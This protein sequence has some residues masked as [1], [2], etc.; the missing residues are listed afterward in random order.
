[1]V[2]SCLIICIRFQTQLLY[3]LMAKIIILKKKKIKIHKNLLMWS[4]LLSSHL[5]LKVTFFLYCHR[6]L[7]MNW[8]SFK[9]SHV[10]IEV[11]TWT[12]LTVLDYERFF[13]Q[14][15]P[16]I[17]CLFVFFSFLSAVALFFYKRRFP[18]NGIKSRTGKTGADDNKTNNVFKNTVNPV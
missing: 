13:K 3:S 1:M 5:Y 18:R 11:I 7:N 12:G 14:H 17:S 10:L 6:K 9:R 4:P 8:T 2:C 15:L 16:S